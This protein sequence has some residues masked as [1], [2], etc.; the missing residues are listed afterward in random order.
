MAYTKTILCLACS[1]KPDGRCVAGKEYSTQ[2][3]TDWIRPVTPGATTSIN[4]AQRKYPDGYYAVALDY[5]QIEFTG[6]QQGVFQAENQL[7]NQPST[8]KL[9]GKADKSVLANIVDSPI[10][11]WSNTCPDSDN[12]INDRVSGRLLTQPCESLYLIRVPQ[13]NVH[14]EIVDERRKLRGEFMYNNTKYKLKITDVKFEKLFENHAEG[15]FATNIDYLTVS[16]GEIFA[17]DNYAYKL[18]AAVF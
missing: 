7:I 1:R 18:I 2:G 11:L 15:V 4:N 5:I 3:I 13:I 8:W 6:S 10:S 9:I 12:G 14:V 17:A 16:L